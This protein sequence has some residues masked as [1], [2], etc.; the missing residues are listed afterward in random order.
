MNF[1]G[2]SGDVSFNENG[3]RVNYTIIMYSGKDEHTG[4]VVRI[5]IH[6]IWFDLISF[7]FLKPKYKEMINKEDKE[8][9]TIENLDWTIAIKKQVHQKRKTKENKVNKNKTINKQTNTQ[10]P[11]HE[12]SNRT[13]EIQSCNVDQHSVTCWLK[14]LLFNTIFC[15]ITSWIGKAKLITANTDPHSNPAPSFEADIV[16]KM[17]PSNSIPNLFL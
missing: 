6:F 10:D 15:R 14:K 2:A 17:Q 12:H 9:E 1:R 16:F 11:K 13:V 4:N 8:K 7:A 5:K 3:D